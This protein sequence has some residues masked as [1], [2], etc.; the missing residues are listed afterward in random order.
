MY[1]E[2]NERKVDTMTTYHIF[3][4]NTFIGSVSGFE[5]AC[6]C[7]ESAANIAEKTCQTVSLVRCDEKGI[8]EIARYDP[9][10]VDDNF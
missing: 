3:I 6:D 9:E 10:E 1:T 2:R 4:G 8:V 5:T 7:Y